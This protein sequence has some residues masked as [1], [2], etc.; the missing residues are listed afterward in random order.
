M[1]HSLRILVV[2]AAAFA[3][4]LIANNAFAQCRSCGRGH[5]Q[6][7]A[8]V[9]PREEADITSGDKFE[10]EGEE[11]FKARQIQNTPQY[12][13]TGPMHEYYQG[14]SYKSFPS[15]SN[16]YKTTTQERIEYRRRCCPW[17]P[18]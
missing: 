13:Y 16:W 7:E 14:R 3:G 2:L 1:H 17:R 15:Y 5:A 8:A 18:W 11:F 4:S 9:W 10:R 6:P 12:H